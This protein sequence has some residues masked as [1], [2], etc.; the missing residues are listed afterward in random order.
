MSNFSLEIVLFS[1]LAFVGFIISVTT[2][3]IM[4]YKVEFELQPESTIAY[5]MP[6][7]F[8][9]NEGEIITEEA[10]NPVFKTPGWMLGKDASRKLNTRS[11]EHTSELQSRGHLLCRLLLE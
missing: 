3:N 11:E 5:E 1:L 6:A 4:D 2:F 9:P 7:I 8:G 10:M